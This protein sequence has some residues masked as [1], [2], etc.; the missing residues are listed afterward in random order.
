MITDEIYDAIKLHFAKEWHV[1]PDKLIILKGK[2]SIEVLTTYTGVTTYYLEFTI[3]YG[4]TYEDY[5]GEI[6]HSELLEEL[7]DL[8]LKNLGL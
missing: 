1:K 2:D 3:D 6:K 4:G 5:W 8:K 7:R